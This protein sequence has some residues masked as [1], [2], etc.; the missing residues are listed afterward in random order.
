MDPGGF[1][2]RVNAKAKSSSKKQKKKTDSQKRETITKNS[3]GVLE[4]TYYK[5]HLDIVTEQNK[6]LKERVEQLERENKDLKNSVYNLSFLYNSCA[7]ALQN[8]QRSGDVDSSPLPFDLHSALSTSYDIPSF[9]KSLDQKKYPDHLGR[10]RSEG[11][12]AKKTDLLGHGGSVYCLKFSPCGKLLAS[13]SFDK[14]VRIWD[15]KST[16]QQSCFEEHQLNVSDLSWSNDSNLLLSGAYD[17][18]VKLWDIQTGTP[19]RNFETAGFVQSVMFEPVY[20]NVF[21]VACTKKQI[22][23]FDPRTGKVCQVFNNNAM[24]NSL[25]V[26]AQGTLLLTG[27]NYGCLKTWYAPSGECICSVDNDKHQ[28]P[29]SHVHA[30]RPNSDAGSRLVAVNSYDNVIRVYDQLQSK[31]SMPPHQPQPPQPSLSPASKSGDPAF[32]DQAQQPEQDEEKSNLHLLHELRSHKNKNWPIRSS[33]YHGY[34]YR[35]KNEWKSGISGSGNTKSTSIP[36]DDEEIETSLDRQTGRASCED[37]ILLATGSVDSHVYVYDVGGPTGSSQMI[38]KLRGH[39][40]MV[41]AAEFHPRDLLLATAS[42][43]FTVRLW[44]PKQIV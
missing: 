39:R 43:D 26:Y 1:G 38:Q 14:T 20:N 17:R 3:E 29:I 11:L 5:N 33:F 16:K 44:A 21:Y 19:L 31:I 9:P 12:L 42:A 28:K 4:Q 41:Y 37:T 32:P 2:W 15:L 36:N 10:G 23:A 25:Y 6:I 22:K 8:G 27:D 34:H 13:G 40:D 7:H 18:T 24:V 30:S 35:G